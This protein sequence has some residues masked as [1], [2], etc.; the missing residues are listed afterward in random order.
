MRQHLTRLMQCAI[1]G[2]LLTGGQAHALQTLTTNPHWFT[3]GDGKGIY[4]T[5]PGGSNEADQ[6]LN[7]INLIQRISASGTAL[8]PCDI[9]A[10][11]ATWL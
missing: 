1:V 2:A 6:C 3:T 11:L 8:P 9:P 5:G 7:S 10:A 4:L